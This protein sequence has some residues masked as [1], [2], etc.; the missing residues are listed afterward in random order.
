MSL[1]FETCYVS[2]GCNK[3]C[4]AA[5]WGRNGL[6]CYAVCNSVAIYDP[7]FAQDSGKVINTLH[8]HTERVN[9]V[10]WLKNPSN[11]SENAFI[12][13]SADGSAIIWSWDDKLCSYIQEVVL[14]G[15]TNVVNIADGLVRL[16]PGNKYI[17]EETPFIAVTC[18]IDS[19]VKIWKRI[20]EKDIRLVD[21]L[22]WGSGFCL[23]VKLVVLPDS[24][25]TVMACAAHDNSIHL[26]CEKGLQE[27]NEEHI[28]E[29]L[30]VLVGHDDWVRGLDFTIDAQDNVYLASASQD[31]F[32]RVYKISQQNPHLRAKRIQNVQIDGELETEVKMVTIQGQTNA[33]HYAISLETILAGHEGW[34]YGVSF[35]NPYVKNSGGNTCGGQ[36]GSGDLRDPRIKLL[37]SSMDKTLIIWSQTGSGTWTEELRLGEVGGNTLGFYGGKFRFDGRAVFAHGFQGSFHMWGFNRESKTWEPKTVVGGHTAEVM[38]LSW[39]VQGNY[40]LSVG[41][42]QTTRLHAPWCSKDTKELTWHEMARPQIHGYDLTSVVVLSEYKFATG[43]EEKVIRA[44]IAPNNFID[45]FQRLSKKTYGESKGKGEDLPQGASVPA[46]GLSNKPV[47]EQMKKEGF[48]VN[49]EYPDLYFSPIHLTKPPTE[50]NLLQNTLWPEVQ[51]LYGHG[52]EI[53]C[54]AARSDGS[55]LAS[56]CKATIPEHAGIILWNAKTWLLVQKLTSHQ[57]TVTQMAFSPNGKYLLSVSRDR[58]WTLFVVQDN[59][60]NYEMLSTG[61]KN[62]LHSRVIWCCAWTCDSETFA[63]G[64]RD[65]KIGIWSEIKPNEQD[66]TKNVKL[67]TSVDIST[68]SV[69]ALAFAPVMTRDGHLMAVGLK[70]GAIHLYQYANGIVENTNISLDGHQLSVKRLSFRPKPGRTGEDDNENSDVI[71]LASCGSDHILKVYDI[72][73]QLL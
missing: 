49:D 34:V 61:D 42:D 57:L 51:K 40:V 44:F 21:S 53:Y 73:F 24:E 35:C 65:G 36:D 30:Y 2:C 70:S 58:R 31:T 56:A 54:L 8:G 14:K 15:H 25:I 27:E 20:D 22:D 28:F 67:M 4:H 60:K 33:Y 5:D 23:D 50:E 3:C 37:S 72:F 32:I 46:L 45:N 59:G 16:C 62:C 6:I 47:F 26:Y 71:Q 55:L 19:T 10:R 52:Y 29:K 69:T 68:D 63:T 38:D 39:D 66:F 7:A 1:N 13:A 48:I 64:S 11:S 18:S 41:S 12:S 43:A 17:P 9:C